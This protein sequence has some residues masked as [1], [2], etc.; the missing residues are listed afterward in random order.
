MTLNWE[1]FASSQYFSFWE[2]YALFSYSFCF[3]WYRLGKLIYTKCFIMKMLYVV[4][5]FLETMK[6]L[7]ETKRL[8]L[9]PHQWPLI[10]SNFRQCIQVSDPSIEESHSISTK[11]LHNNISLLKI[12]CD[13]FFFLFWFKLMR[14]WASLVAQ[15]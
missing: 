7:I 8:L 13:L 2:Y 11:Y 10:S 12:P 4:H 1:E 14:T 6:T 5:M 9:R 15:W 3:L